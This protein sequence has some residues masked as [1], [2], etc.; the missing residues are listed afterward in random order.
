[1][2]K[3]FGG[4][5]AAIIISV[6]IAAIAAGIFAL[7]VSSANLGNRSE[8]N[9][10]SVWENNQNILGQY[11]LK[12]QEMAQVPD[13]YKNDLKEVMTSVMTARQ[14]PN[15]SQATVQFFKEHNIQIDTGMY[16][17]IQQV[18]E[19]GRNEFQANQTRLIDVKQTYRERLG[20]IPS[21]WFLGMA[22]YPTIKVGYPNADIDDFK[23]IVA[24][25]TR[26]AFKTGVQAP[27]KLR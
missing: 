4:A 2:K 24:V 3:Q 17:K 14:G 5:V 1:M 27:V 19:A 12:I 22:G 21:K 13:M 25:D 8:N 16:T 23:P 9:I 26:D 15:G 20:A 6:V 11:T 10:K 7:Y 18:Q